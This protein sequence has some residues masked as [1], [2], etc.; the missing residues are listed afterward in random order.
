MPEPVSRYHLPLFFVCARVIAAR[1]KF[2]LAAGDAGQDVERGLAPG[3]RGGIGRRSDENE[4]VIHDVMTLDTVTLGDK[5][6]FRGFGVY[7]QQVAV[8]VAGVFQSLPGSDRN[9]VD[10]D[11][12]LALEHRQQV[13]VETGYF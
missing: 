3:D 10:G 4:I 2:R 7:Q 12:G 6:L 9:H 11:A 8:A 13:V 5:F 1:G